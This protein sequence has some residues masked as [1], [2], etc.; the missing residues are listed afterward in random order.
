LLP[1]RVFAAQCLPEQKGS[2]SVLVL[3]AYQ[4]GLTTATGIATVIER[5]LSTRTA[6]EIETDRSL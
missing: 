5:L 4:S 6:I 1:R 3:V 2:G